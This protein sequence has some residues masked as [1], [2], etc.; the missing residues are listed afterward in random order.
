[1]LGSFDIDACYNTVAA[2]PG[3][4]AAARIREGYGVTHQPR[5]GIGISGASGIA[6]DIDVGV[7]RRRREPEAAGEP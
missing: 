2:A 1:V 6:H 7:A 4:A 3:V 5:R